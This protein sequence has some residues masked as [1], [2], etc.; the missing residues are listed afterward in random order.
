MKKILLVAVLAIGLG[1]NAQI[2]DTSPKEP[3]VKT[4]ARWGEGYFYSD[5]VMFSF[6]DTSTTND[7]RIAPKFTYTMSLDEVI[8]VYSEIEKRCSSKD[9]KKNEF[10]FTNTGGEEI[11]VFL[12]S[13]FGA[14]VIG[15]GVEVKLKDASVGHPDAVLLRYSGNQYSLGQVKKIFNIK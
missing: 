15:F 10:T 9:F 14:K 1:M 5:H 6:P 11:K 7:L 8:V 2:K 3:L 4:S 13:Y 12:D